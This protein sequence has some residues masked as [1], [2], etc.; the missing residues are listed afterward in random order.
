MPGSYWSD[1]LRVRLSRRR[2]LQAAGALGAGAVVL[3]ALD[4][5]GKGAGGPSAKN[6]GIA[7]EPVDTTKQAVRGG[8][9][10]SFMESEG[11]NFDA[12]TATAQVAAHA[13]LAY[14]RIVKSKLGTF[15]NA[16]DGSVEG[17][18]AS[19]WELSP[20]GL[21]VTFKMRP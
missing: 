4:C 14:N 6:L 5:G 19:S 2:V 8:T 18:A 10:Q 11:V 13:D 9:M 15:A 7:T 17:D 16:P 3:S 1:H 12:T 21:Q 20:D